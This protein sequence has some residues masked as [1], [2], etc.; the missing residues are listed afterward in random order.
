MDK[1]IRDGKVAVLF[2]PGY[3]GGWSTWWC[4]PEEALF[5]PEMVEAV[6]AGDRDKAAVIAARKWPDAYTGGVGQM[7]VEWVPQGMAFRITEYDGSESVE[8]YSPNSYTTA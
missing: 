6:L 3:G 8:L 1:V 2:S 7:H 4:S 5:D